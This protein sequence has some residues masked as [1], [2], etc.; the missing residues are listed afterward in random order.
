MGAGA[1]SLKDIAAADGRAAL[2]ADVAESEEGESLVRGRRARVCVCA[3]TRPG[4]CGEVCCCGGGGGGVG[5]RGGGSRSARWQG[6]GT[7]EF[8]SAGDAARAIAALDGAEV[9]G[10]A[11]FARLDRGGR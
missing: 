5:G 11:L 7:V 3:R 1:Q 8:A 2:Y 6:R 10:R 4:V 9:E